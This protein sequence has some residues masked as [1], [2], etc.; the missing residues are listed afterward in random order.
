MKVEPSSRTIVQ[1]MQAL[2]LFFNNGNGK[3]EK[4]QK[5]SKMDWRIVDLVVKSTGCSYRG[6]PFGSQHPY[7]GL[8]PSMTLVS[9]NL[10][11]LLCSEGS[12]TYMVHRHNLA[13][14]EIHRYCFQKDL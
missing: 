8:Q 2:S 9:E 1:Y 7:G 6:S 5:K 12:S 11:P 13:H 10:M 4:K 14:T 3:E